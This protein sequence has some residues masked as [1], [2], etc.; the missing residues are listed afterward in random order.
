MKCTTEFISSYEG[1]ANH[2]LVSASEKRAW[3]DGN[4]SSI[5]WGIIAAMHGN[6]ARFHVPGALSQ[7]L[8]QY[9]MPWAFSGERI[10]RSKSEFDDLVRAYLGELEKVEKL[11]RSKPISAVRN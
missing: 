10:V 8:A 7:H 11:R 4:T 3:I 5:Y 2:W 1:G 9:K 6:R